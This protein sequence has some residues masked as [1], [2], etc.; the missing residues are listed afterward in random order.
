LKWSLIG[1]PDHQGVIH[2]GG[3]I[4]AAYGP[5]AF[6]KQLI[7]MKGRDGV[8]ESMSDHGDVEISEDIQL[9][10]QSA[11]RAIREAHDANRLTVVIGGSHDHGYSHLLGLGGPK[12]KLGCMNIDAHLDVRKPAPLVSSGS[13]FY[14]ALESGVIQPQ[15]FVEFGI[16][17]HCN[18]PELWKYIESK[19]AKVVP[20]EALRSGR[21]VTVFARELKKLTS[22]CDVVAVSLDLDA[23][24]MAYAPGVS[25][26]QSEGF[27]ASEILEMMQISGKSSRVASLGIFELNPVHDRDEQTSRLAANAAYSFVASALRR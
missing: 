22:S 9:N 4:G 12:I 26:P 10:H 20:F 19:K 6:R 3:R 8:L 23:A 13:P 16:Q 18:A 21:A 14:L 1:I 11:A 5:E 24:A 27:T 15:H 2:V 7:K 25:A 17:P